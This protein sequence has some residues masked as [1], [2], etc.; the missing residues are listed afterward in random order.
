MTVALVS[1]GAVAF[2]ATAAMIQFGRRIGFVDLPD[3]ALKDHTGSPVPLGGVGV[4]G[5]LVAGL[6]LADMWDP[7]LG[8]SVLVVFVVGL[9][10]DRIG[11]SPLSRLL[12]VAAAGLVLAVFSPGVEGP[13]STLAAVGLVLVS[14][15]SVNLLDGLDGLAGSVTAIG[16]LGLAWFGSIVGIDD[17]WAPTLLAAALLGFLVFNLH[18]ARSFLGDNGAYVVGVT[19]AWAVL[20]IGQ[21]WTAGLVATALLGVPLLELGATVFRRLLDRAPLFSGDRDHVYD[22]MRRSGVPVARVSLG[23]ASAQTAWIVIVVGVWALLGEVTAVISALVG[24]SV[25]VVAAG[26]MALPEPEAG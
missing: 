4:I 22:R 15:N 26:R 19:L 13:W 7:G 5:G 9:V 3:G 8:L 23:F 16:A 25:I 14:V 17:P 1:A 24:G 20:R 2:V 10:D 12:L 11:L 6:A 18:P 21:T